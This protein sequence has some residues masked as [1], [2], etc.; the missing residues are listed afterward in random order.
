MNWDAALI[1]ILPAMRRYALFLSRNA[2]EADDIVNDCVVKVL[3]SKASFDQ[4]RALRPWVFQIM[5]N[6]F[7][8]SRKSASSSNHFPIDDVVALADETAHLS[9]TASIEVRETLTALMKL[10]EDSKDV[11]ILVAIEGFS[12]KEA[13]VCLGVPIGTVMSRISRA[14]KQLVETLGHPPANLRQSGRMI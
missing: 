9:Q 5:R 11:L 3:S 2:H 7:L 6:I 1:E 12:Y 10:P 8:D 13:A 14:R 4:S